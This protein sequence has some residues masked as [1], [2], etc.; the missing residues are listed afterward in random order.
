MAS[1]GTLSRSPKDLLTPSMTV[2]SL[3][4]HTVPSDR[5]AAVTRRDLASCGIPARALGRVTP[6]FRVTLVGCVAVNEHARAYLPAA[7]GGTADGLD[8]SEATSRL[9][10]ASFALSP[11]AR[12]RPPSP[13]SLGAPWSSPRPS[14]LAPSRAALVRAASDAVDAAE[15]AE[16]AAAG[17]AAAAENAIIQRERANA[18]LSGAQRR[19]TRAH[20]RGSLLDGED[21]L[22]RPRAAPRPPSPRDGVAADLEARLDAAAAAAAPDT[23]RDASALG[24]DVAPRDVVLATGPAALGLGAAAAPDRGTLPPPDGSSDGSEGARSDDDEEEAAV[25]DTYAALLRAQAAYDGR[26]AE[27]VLARQ[28]AAA[29]AAR[30]RE[31]RSAADTSCSALSSAGGAS[32]GGPR[33]PIDAAREQQSLAASLSS[34]GLKADV[35]AGLL[36]HRKK[37]PLIMK[38]MLRRGGS[39][40]ACPAE[41]DDLP[42]LAL[43]PAWQ[44]AQLQEYGLLM[45][46]TAASKAATTPG[47]GSH[48]LRACEELTGASFDL[49]AAD[50]IATEPSTSRSRLW[51]SAPGFCRSPSSRSTCGSRTIATS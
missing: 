49:F 4:Y 30:A 29:G 6:E 8:A 26:A 34:D 11:A 1:A 14:P 13:P 18:V 23:A 9:S 25:R 35:I 42:L 38:A 41:L 45:L 32:P 37:F 51:T 15:T 12:L 5:I 24:A 36:G 33:P 19:H 47:L 22:Q 44:A 48:G 7:L 28:R 10:E 2:V 17:A 50:A 16:G 20:P 40:D 31:L 21:A 43:L 27:A 3:K 46:A 39:P